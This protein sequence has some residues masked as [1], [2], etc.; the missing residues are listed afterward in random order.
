MAPGIVR[1]HGWERF[2]RDVWHGKG[3]RRVLLPLMLRR[4]GCGRRCHGLGVD[5]EGVDVSLGGGWKGNKFSGG[6]E[7]R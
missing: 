6:D 3:L 2:V 1:I 5:R 7:G 4:D